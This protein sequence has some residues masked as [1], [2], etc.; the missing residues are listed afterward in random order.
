MCLGSPSR[1][2]PKHRTQ[3]QHVAT[4]PLRS[5]PRASSCIANESKPSRHNEALP[6]L[7]GRPG[8]LAERPQKSC[9]FCSNMDLCYFSKKNTRCED[10]MPGL[11]VHDPHREEPHDYLKAWVHMLYKRT[12][13][14]HFASLSGKMLSL[15]TI[16]W[17][18]TRRV[19]KTQN[20]S[21]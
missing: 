19:P 2:V 1:E 20:T 10:A 17:N 3:R 15:N 16:L 18:L 21:P 8:D 5:A 9:C 4:E 7:D 14:A 12:H 11:P 13:V 6:G